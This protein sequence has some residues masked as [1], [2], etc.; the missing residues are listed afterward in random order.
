MSEPGNVL[1]N[2]Y[3]NE[4][5]DQPQIDTPLYGYEAVEQ[6]LC[7]WLAEQSLIAREVWFGRPTHYTDQDT[8]YVAWE[9][10]GKGREDIP[11]NTMELSDELVQKSNQQDGKR[12][13]FCMVIASKPEDPFGLHT[14]LRFIDY[15]AI[16]PAVIA[17]A[18]AAVRAR[19]SA[20]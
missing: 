4:V 19:R 20:K 2:Y 14:I 13:E 9:K 15:P 6:Y 1:K 8:G 18:L 11:T 16:D 3:T 12:G 17:E 7:G 5:L 10:D